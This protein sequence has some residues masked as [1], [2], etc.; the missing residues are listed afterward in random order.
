MRT[1]ITL[2]VDVAHLVQQA[3]RREQASFKTV[4]NNAIR[5][6]LGSTGARETAPVYQVRPHESR[7]LAGH[8]VSG[9]NRLSDELEDEAVLASWAERDRDHP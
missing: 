8:D 3:M 9:F 2:E 4:V 7:L 6:G 5:R 1:T